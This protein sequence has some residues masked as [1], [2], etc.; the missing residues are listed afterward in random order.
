[1]NVYLLTEEEINMELESRFSRT[2][3]TLRQRQERLQRFIDIEDQKTRRNHAI[4]ALRDDDVCYHWAIEKN[5][6]TIS[7]CPDCNETLYC[8]QGGT[9]VSIYQLIIELKRDIEILKKKIQI[10]HE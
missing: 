8:E 9:L 3:G 4:A 10:S 6:D 5:P 2:T 7:T 1:M